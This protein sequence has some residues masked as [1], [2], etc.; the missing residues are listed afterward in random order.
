M[1]VGPFYPKLFIEKI[2][3]DKATIPA[4]LCFQV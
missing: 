1:T 4:N 3:V 2:S